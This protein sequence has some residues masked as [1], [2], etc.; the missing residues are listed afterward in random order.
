MKKESNLS[1]G[2]NR[3]LNIRKQ[4]G[5]S[6]AQLTRIAMM[7]A[8]VSAMSY[9]RIPLPFSEAA[10]TGQTLAVNMIALLLTPK[11]AFVA[12]LCY[13]L[14][15]LVGAPVFGGMA[16]PGKMFGPSGGYFMAFVL[17]VV[18]IGAFRGRQY[19]LSRYIVVTVLVGV[20]VIDAIGFVWLKFVTGISWKSALVAG[21]VAFVPLDIAK[22]VT[23]SI[24]VKPL[25]R[26]L[27]ILE[28]SK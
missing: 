9:V 17:A 21:V 26:A 18:L 6:T 10:I 23:A 15:G 1:E 28:A 22:C 4:K 14:L 5:L 25:Q 8:F 3:K 19:K 16:G 11:E 27:G 2:A 7:I 12:M 20:F 24:V 13:W